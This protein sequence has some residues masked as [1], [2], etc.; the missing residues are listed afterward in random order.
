MPNGMK[1]FLYEWRLR[2]PHLREANYT[3][4]GV[5][6]EATAMNKHGYTHSTRCGHL[7]QHG[8]CEEGRGRMVTGIQEEREEK[9]EENGRQRK[10]G[11]TN[12]GTGMKQSPLPQTTT[13]LI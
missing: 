1:V 7:C 6:L 8:L 11:R 10:A 2:C 13:E 4:L 3:V 9:T 5:S 12:G